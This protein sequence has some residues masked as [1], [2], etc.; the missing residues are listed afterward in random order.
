MVA[1]T[2]QPYAENENQN[3][4][5]HH[6]KTEVTPEGFCSDA[7][8]RRQLQKQELQRAVLTAR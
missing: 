5:F 3:K 2:F 4:L 8:V 7:T 6:L 1:L